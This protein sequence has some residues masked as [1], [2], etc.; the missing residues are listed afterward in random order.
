MK[1]SAITTDSQLVVQRLHE[2]LAERD[3]AI[4]HRVMRVHFQIAV[5][6]QREIHHRVL[7]EKGEHV[8]EK[9]NPRLHPGVTLP[10]QLQLQAD[11]RLFRI[12]TDL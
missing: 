6:T 1:T 3:A 2:R 9:R 12:A 4:L 11:A 7:R 10:I 5:T 8:V